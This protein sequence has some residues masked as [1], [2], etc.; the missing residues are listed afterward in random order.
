MGLASEDF[1]KA[2]D[3]LTGSD[4]ANIFCDHKRCMIRKKCE[5]YKGKIP[6]LTLQLSN[7]ITYRIP[8]DKL[9]RDHHVEIPNKGKF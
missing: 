1:S 6:K 5:D 9:L 2:V 7:R 8:G 4:P 3:V